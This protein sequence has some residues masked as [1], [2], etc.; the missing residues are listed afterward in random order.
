[1][2]T[3]KTKEEIAILRE[4]GRRH[5]E[6]MRALVSMVKTGISTLDLENEAQKLIKAGGDGTDKPAFL[7]YSPRGAKRP[8]PA[9]LCISINN[10][11]VHGIPNED[12]QV[13]KD[14]DIV[15]LDMGLVHKGMYTDMAVT[16]P[17]GGADKTSKQAMRLV[18]TA[19]EAL[20]AGI[21]A[22]RGGAKIGDIGAAI[23]RIVYPTGF[24][25][26]PELCGHGVGYSVH[27][28]PYV[29]NYG[30]AGTGEVLRPGMVLAIEPILAEKGPRIKLSK[31]GY[32][33]VTADGG[34][35]VQEEHTIVIT[36]GEAEILTL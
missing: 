33:Y 35:A 20:K 25:I 21:K 2:I 22:A 4:G 34:L 26:I 19:K 28:D 8:Y 3:I 30:N 1:M 9:A 7:N 18:N 11:V 15:T 14:G 24:A 31:D 16:V 5:A 12:P 29:P 23:E 17:V 13:L 27:E 10:Q 36:K 32:T 6:I